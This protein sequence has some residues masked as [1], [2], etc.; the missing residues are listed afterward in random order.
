MNEGPNIVKIAALVGD[1][2]RASMLT[3]LMSG[4]ALTATELSTEANITKQTTSS[5]LAKMKEAGLVSVIS[6][7]R[8]RY[9]CLADRDVAQLLESLMGIA[10]RTGATRVR[11][12]P[13]DPELRRA[14]VCYDHL[15]GD[16]AVELYDRFLKFGYIRISNATPESNP[17][18]EITRKGQQFC[19]THEIDIAGLTKSRRPVCRSCLDWSERRFHLAGSLGAGILNYCYQHKL[20]KRID[21]TRVV[22][23]SPK[24]ETEFKA[25]FHTK[26]D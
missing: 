5:H 7:G 12:G 4:K 26:S 22:K 17:E 21:G 11:P 6:Q 8:H 13:R 3:A 10:Q 2:A 19:S 1:N 25:L 23:F 14:R 18:I 15:A 20:A 9:F 24:G 16:M